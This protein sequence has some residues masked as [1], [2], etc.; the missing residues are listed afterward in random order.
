MRIMIALESRRRRSRNE[1]LSQEA[2]PLRQENDALRRE[3]AHLRQVDAERQATLVAL[4]QH[5]ETC[6]EQIALLKKAL[7]APRRERFIPSPDQKL[8]FAPEPL[9]E[10]SAAPAAEE[11]ESDHAEVEPPKASGKPRRKRR[12]RFEFPQCLPVRRFEHPLPPEQ[13]ACP[14]GC[15]GE[16]VV[17]SEEIS[18]QLEYIPPSA[19][20]AEHVRYTYG[21]PTQRAGES[22]VTSEKPAHINDKGVLGSST[23]AWLAQ[24]K[25]E[26]HL[27]L[28]RLQEELHT[29]S[30]MWFERSVLSGTLIRAARGLRPLWDLIHRLALA[31]FYLRVDE[32]TGRVLRPGTGKTGLVYVWVYVGDDDHPYQLFDYRLDRSRAGPQEI[33]RSFSGGLLTDGHSAYTALIKESEKRLIDLGCWA[34]YPE[35]GFIRSQV[36]GSLHGQAIRMKT[37]QWSPDKSWSNSGGTL[38]S[39]SAST[40]T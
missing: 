26:R 12:K 35:C 33:L 34:H 7:F 8:L 36:D 22:I 21:C 31:S 25:F 15:G 13:R 4:Q 16:R 2:D 18:K 11:T 32:T 20:V 17:I 3:I 19:Y 29:A 27:P 37:V 14:C 9:D 24:A 5:L 28:Y 40:I 1:P 38:G 23:I 30:R 39:G 10:S 6:Q